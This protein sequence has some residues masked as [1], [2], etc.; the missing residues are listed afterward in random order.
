VHHIFHE[1]PH[2]NAVAANVYLKNALGDLYYKDTKT[3]SEA[4]KDTFRLI[5]VE[6]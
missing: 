3:L 5:C 4:I 1:L 2:Y 6:H